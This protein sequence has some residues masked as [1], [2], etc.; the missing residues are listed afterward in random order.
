MF[1]FQAVSNPFRALTV[2]SASHLYP[3][4][5]SLQTYLS[6]DRSYSQPSLHTNSVLGL[7]Y[8]GTLCPTDH[9]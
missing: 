8:G 3:H 5:T 7:Y 1:V 6:Y 9:F 4:P 2:T